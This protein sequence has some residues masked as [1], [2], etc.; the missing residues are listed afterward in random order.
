MIVAH[1]ARIA[2]IAVCTFAL[3]GCS[4]HHALGSPAS[5]T[6][7]AAVPSQPPALHVNPL[8]GGPPTHSP[9]VA[10]KVDDTADGRPQ[11]GIDSADIVYIE[12]VEGGLTRLLAVFET[13]L[14][15]V[16]AVRSTR[17]GD[18]EIALQYGP[19]DYVASGGSD[20]ELKPLK[21]SKLRWTVGDK[22]GPGFGRDPS[23]PVPFNLTAD[24]ASIAKRLKGPTAKDIGLTWTADITNGGVIPAT[25]VRTVV[26]GTAI[27]FDWSA[28][29][30]RYVRIIND[31][32]AKAADGNVVATPNVVVQS[33]QVT[34][35]NGDIDQSGSPAKVTHT[36]GQGSVAVFR[37][38]RRINGTWHR[39]TVGDVTH[40]VDTH[41]RPITLAPGGAW[42]VLVATGTPIS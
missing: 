1:S 20:G 4:S 36:I 17:V 11:V 12:Q 24:L 13:K 34:T 14:P 39:A 15:K 18:P 27:E 28:A 9:A 29:R 33:C 22:G 25:K 38:G 3:A 30:H 16:E 23:R 8:T 40:L 41:G 2:A 6:T 32:P 42:F 10:V 26:G 31:A 7:S 37:D 21:A 5:G 19:I 35:F